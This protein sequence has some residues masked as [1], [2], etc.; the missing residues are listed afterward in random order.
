VPEKVTVALDGFGAE[1]GFHVVLQSCRGTGGSAGE[2]VWWRNEAA[3]G[4]VAIA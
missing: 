2:F 1:Q 3:D 4:Q